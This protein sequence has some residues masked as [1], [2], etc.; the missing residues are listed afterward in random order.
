MP[1]ATGIQHSSNKFIL[2]RYKQFLWRNIKSSIIRALPAILLDKS[3]L[4][5]NLNVMRTIIFSAILFL[6]SA[7][8]FSQQTIPQQPLIHQDYLK[9]SKN[10]KKAGNIILAS[11]GGLIVASFLIPNGELIHSNCFIFYCQTEYQND[12][13]KNGVLIAGVISAISSIPLFIIAAKNRRKATSVSFKMENTTH[14]YNQNI[15]NTS[16]P[17]LRIKT[18]F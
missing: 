17:A 15:V 10:L 13:L 4:N 1:I 2:W 12:R 18:N 11:G 8:S 16:F 7:S 6:I 14:L 9:K 3:I 5:L